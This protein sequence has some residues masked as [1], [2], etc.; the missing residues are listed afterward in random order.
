[1]YILIHISMHPLPP[2]LQYAIDDSLPFILNILLAQLY[3]LFGT[4]VITCYGLPWFTLLLVP[5]GLLYYHMQKY[6]RRT[7]RYMYMYKG[8]VHNCARA[9]GYYYTHITM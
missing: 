9:L 2:S 1:M 7:S 4:L 6:Y 5:L 3:G 8:R